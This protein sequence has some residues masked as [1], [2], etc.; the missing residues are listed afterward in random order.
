MDSLEGNDTQVPLTNHFTRVTNA[1][2]ITSDKKGPLRRQ[3]LDIGILPLPGRRTS[4][5][6]WGP[7]GYSVGVG[8]GINSR[9]TLCWPCPPLWRIYPGQLPWAPRGTK[10]TTL[11]PSVLPWGPVI[12]AWVVCTVR[13]DESHGGPASRSAPVLGDL[14]ANENEKE[15]RR[16]TRGFLHKGPVSRTF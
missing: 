10:R 13:G 9:W 14:G 5:R 6:L 2:P 1:T 8:F 15:V 16:D 7:R 3:G 11:L 4:G 12:A